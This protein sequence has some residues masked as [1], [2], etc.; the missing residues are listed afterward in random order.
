MNNYE[1]MYIV[2]GSLSE[3]DANKVA[4]AVEKEITRFK[5]K[6]LQTDK[7]GKRKFAYKIK[8]MTDGFYFLTNF[9]VN[10]LKLKE[11][12]GD[13]KNMDNVIRYLVVKLPEKALK[14]KKA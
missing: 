10:P 6:V 1:I 3:N 11:L 12:V 5:G 9:S 13:I 7:W 2:R 14:E 4:G 8:T